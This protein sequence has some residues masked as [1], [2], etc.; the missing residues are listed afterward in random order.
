MWDI[1]LEDDKAELRRVQNKEQPELLAGS[2]PSDDFSS[3]LNTC[4][5]SR[6][7]K[8]LIAGRKAEN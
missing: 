8:S 5:K 6:D 2:P 7:P 3:L 4:V 1:S